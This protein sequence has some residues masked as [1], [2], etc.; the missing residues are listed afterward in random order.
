MSMIEVLLMPC[1]RF[2]WFLIGEDAR[3]LVF[4]TYHSSDFEANDSAKVYRSRFRAIGKI[5]DSYPH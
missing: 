5:V 2:R 1:G 4:G 3:Q